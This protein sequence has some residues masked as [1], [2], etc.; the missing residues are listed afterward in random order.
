MSS[1]Y[2]KYKTVLINT[3]HYEISNRLYNVIEREIGSLDIMR[4]LFYSKIDLNNLVGVGANTI[5]EINN[6]KK[7]IL[8][9]NDES[10]ANDQNLN[11]EKINF[12]KEL[13]KINITDAIFDIPTVKLLLFSNGILDNPKRFYS[14]SK[15]YKSIGSL[16]GYT[17]EKLLRKKGIGKK[18]VSS[19]WE[20]IECFHM[21][22]FKELATILQKDKS[23][24]LIDNI[25]FSFTVDQ[26]FKKMEILRL[27]DFYKIDTYKPD[28]LSNIDKL[29]LLELKTLYFEK[30][31]NCFSTRTNHTTKDI[32]LIADFDEFIQK[33]DKSN[34]ELILRRWNCEEPFLM[35]VIGDEHDVTRE[36]IRQLL[37]K[38]KTEY[39]NLYIDD[40]EYIKDFLYSKLIEQTTPLY[41]KNLSEEKFDNKYNDYFYENFF[42][43]LLTHIPI[44]K[45][46]WHVQ[47]KDS[48]VIIKF[49]KLVKNKII[50]LPSILNRFEKKE[51]IEIINFSYSNNSNVKV[52]MPNK[53]IF[54]AYND[55]ITWE[56]NYNQLKKYV[57]INHRPPRTD[58]RVKNMSDEEKNIAIWYRTQRRYSREG[59]QT[60]YRLNKLKKIL[61]NIDQREK[62]ERH[63]WMESYKDYI[64]FKNQF[65]REPFQKN[66]KSEIESRLGQ[67]V[68]LNK[69]RFHGTS[70]T[71]SPLSKEQMRL[72]NEID[73]N[74]NFNSRVGKNYTTLEKFTEKLNEYIKYR[75]KMFKDS[76][77]PKYV[78]KYRKIK[79]FNKNNLSKEKIKL[80]LQNKI[81][82]PVEEINNNWKD[83]YDTAKSLINLK[84]K[85]LSKKIGNKYNLLYKWVLFNQACYEIEML[86]EERTL[87]LDNLDIYYFDLE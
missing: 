84:E 37:S 81:S 73:F 28:E 23:D 76:D 33:C 45:T 4:F 31:N 11:K 85:N 25:H 43:E 78:W 38:I 86:S 34:R 82:F 72:L 42:R 69:Q 80:F 68:S 21:G 55:V 24:V 53:K 62:S 63:S 40:I 9:D 36:R 41:R 1:K 50:S 56:K 26:L 13:E 7:K 75:E 44:K 12:I 70:K 19:F 8:S 51:V 64:N 6:L 74:F 49:K 27:S 59:T 20:L 39:I 57:E 18:V 29:A 65:N 32:N 52:F 16:N 87:L 14:I 60:K 46:N 48:K 22:S 5:K 54:F 79:A 17:K 67:W 47:L 77:N 71:N 58:L 66:I 61:P 83:Y 3:V 15:R 35:K 30:N 10:F 2:K